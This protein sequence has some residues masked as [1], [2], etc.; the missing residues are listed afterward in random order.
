M[1][2]LSSSA[3][4]YSVSYPGMEHLHFNAGP[5]SIHPGAN[6]ILVDYNHVP[7]PNQD[8]YMVRFVPNLRYALPNGKCC[9]K[10]PMVSVIHLHHG[11]WLSNGKAGEGEGNS[12]YG[13]VYPFM[14]TGEEKTITTFP[15]AGTATQSRPATSGSSTT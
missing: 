2:C 7:K 10:I 11:V 12:Y 3:A 8:G 5:Y 13:S 9:G 14:A 1:A 4:A 15:Q 6:L